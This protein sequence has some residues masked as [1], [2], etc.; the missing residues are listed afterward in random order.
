M[1]HKTSSSVCFHKE[2]VPD[3]KNREFEA[4]TL[5]MSSQTDSTA[6]IG[7]GS[8]NHGPMMRMEVASGQERKEILQFSK[9][10]SLSLISTAKK[11]AKVIVKN[12]QKMLYS[13]TMASL[14]M[15]LYKE[16]S[17]TVGSYPPLPR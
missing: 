17:E 11:M 3:N 7:D 12:Y 8:L 2:Q 1:A 4:R 16:I 14:T 13:S 5:E 15:T 9:S 6:K 10:L